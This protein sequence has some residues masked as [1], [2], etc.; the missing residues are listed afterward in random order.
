MLSLLIKNYVS[1]RRHCETTEFHLSKERLFQKIKSDF[2]IEQI[3]FIVLLTHLAFI[4]IKIIGKTMSNSR[5]ES[6]SH[7]AGKERAPPV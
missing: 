2:K 5:K 6:R 3:H 4:G 1:L 7:T